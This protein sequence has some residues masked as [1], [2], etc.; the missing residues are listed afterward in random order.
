[1]N[2]EAIQEVMPE[3]KKLQIAI[4][5]PGNLIVT[6]PGSWHMGYNTGSCVQL[7]C[8]LLPACNT[9]LNIAQAMNE[10]ASPWLSLPPSV[11]SCT[12][13]SVVKFSDEELLRIRTAF[14]A[15]NTSRVRFSQQL[16]MND[17]FVSDEEYSDIE[18]EQES[19]SA[20]STKT[21]RKITAKPSRKNKTARVTKG[22]GAAKGD[23]AQ[24]NESPSHR[25][26]E[27]EQT[28]IR[29]TS[30]KR[31]HGRRRISKYRDS[32]AG[33]SSAAS[34]DESVGSETDADRRF[35]SSS[36]ASNASQHPHNKGFDVSQ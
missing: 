5:L 34:D 36:Q 3:G 24:L 6:T 27:V 23:T 28:R 29:A 33:A 32:Q 22:A 10:V 30:S 20:A 4:Q 25:K 15:T 1:M 16:E 18:S 26:S 8:V 7:V 14:N 13:S 19:E 21:K 17:S 11:P 35:I 9:G 2:P 31:T 12:C